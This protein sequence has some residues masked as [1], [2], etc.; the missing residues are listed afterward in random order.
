MFHICRG[1]PVFQS[2]A[3]HIKVSVLLKNLLILIK[4]NISW[5]AL[6]EVGQNVKIKRKRRSIEKGAARLIYRIHSFNFNIAPY[7]LKKYVFWL[8]IVWSFLQIM[9]RNLLFSSV[10]NEISTKE[11]FES[12]DFWIWLTLWKWWKTWLPSH[13]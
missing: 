10:E 1:L 6:K 8:F 9:P 12:V 11:D 2:L 5:V 4:K 3:L 7:Y 13:G